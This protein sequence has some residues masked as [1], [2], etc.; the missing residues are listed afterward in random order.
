MDKECKQTATSPGELNTR[1]APSAMPGRLNVQCDALPGCPSRWRRC[2]AH[3]SP[4]R[5]RSDLQLL[6]ESLGIT[7]QIAWIGM[8]FLCA[9]GTYA[10]VM[11][12][13]Q[14]Y[15]EG[16][17]FFISLRLR[18]RPKYQKMSCQASLATS[19]EK[20]S[21]LVTLQL[22]AEQCF[23]HLYTTSAFQNLSL[24]YHEV[25]ILAAQCLVLIAANLLR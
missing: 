1:T 4:K 17:H 16:S 25:A 12:K 7:L 8:A 14:V 22:I 21:S 6:S 18:A 11:L 5:G 23:I 15:I 13:A 9:I 20:I 19:N 24:I 10:Q 3:T 2:A